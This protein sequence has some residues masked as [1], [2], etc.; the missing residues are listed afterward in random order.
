MGRRGKLPPINLTDDERAEL[1]RLVRRQKSAQS[2]ARRARIVLG[3]ADG[4]TNTAVA[5]ELRI[6]NDTVGI[7]R[8]RFVEHRLDGLFDE[9]RPGAPR[10]VG[11]D[12]IEQLIVKTLDDKPKNAT[13]WSTRSMAKATGMSQSTVSRVWRAFGLRPHRVDNFKLST[14]PMFIDKVRDV[15]GLYMSP[16]ENAVVLCVDEKSQIQALERSQPVLP[17]MPARPE[18][19]THDYIRNGTTTLFAALDVATGK[20]I[21]R[22]HRKHRADE[23]K[24]FLKTIDEE[25]P[26]DFDIHVVL[27]NYGTHKTPA[28]QSWLLRHPRFHMHFTPTY[29]SWLNL[30]ERWF[31]EITNK[32]IR[33]GSFRSTQALE[34]AI[35]DF[36]DENNEEPKPF[37]WAKTADE[38][39]ASVS[40][41]CRDC[42]RIS[43][44]DF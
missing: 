12:K 26:D 22:L 3:C 32:C 9:P 11:D 43:T 5:R 27:D 24:A 35:R 39:L 28:I 33:R 15:V 21:G 8:R 30:V 2:I 20:V 7:W 17:M 25:V 36:V 16:P 23:F 4:K 37:V 10:K 40:A 19:Q 41:Y 1:E 13:H 31:A 34:K 18:Q 44:E 14:D 6:G 29:S 38:I 42:S